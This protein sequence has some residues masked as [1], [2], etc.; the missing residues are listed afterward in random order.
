MDVVT[1]N[2]GTRHFAAACMANE[3]HESLHVQQLETFIILEQKYTRL[4]KCQWSGAIQIIKA[5]RDQKC[6]RH[7]VID[8]WQCCLDVF[9]VMSHDGILFKINPPLTYK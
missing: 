8:D 7:V 2:K 3:Y 4:L 5:S 9:F 6:L 1:N